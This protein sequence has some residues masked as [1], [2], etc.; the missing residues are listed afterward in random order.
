MGDYPGY[1]DGPNVI[2]RV[3]KVK[4]GGQRGRNREIVVGERPGSVLLALRTQEELTNQGV[5]EAS[6]RGKARTWILP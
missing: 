5:L 1:L 4:G 3:F 2:T 6:R